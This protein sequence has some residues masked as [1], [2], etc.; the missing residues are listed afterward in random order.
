MAKRKCKVLPF[1]APR[2]DDFS[3]WKHGFGSV[4]AQWLPRWD[5]TG[6]AVAAQRIN[7]LSDFSFGIRAIPFYGF[8]LLVRT[9]LKWAFLRV[10]VSAFSFSPAI[11]SG[12]RELEVS[13]HGG[14]SLLSA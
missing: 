4:Y 1:W 11:L 9:S 5:A 10:A 14:V 3:R 7:K 8:S 13:L 12:D 6:A 2:S